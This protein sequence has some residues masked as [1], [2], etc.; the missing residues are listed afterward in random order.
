MDGGPL[1]LPLGGKDGG[2]EAEHHF[3]E[4]DPGGDLIGVPGPRRQ[5][6][7]TGNKNVGMADGAAVH[8]KWDGTGC[9]GVVRCPLP[10]I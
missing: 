5:S 6:T 3:V 8:N 4:E 2:A 7:A 9:A 1:R 10:A